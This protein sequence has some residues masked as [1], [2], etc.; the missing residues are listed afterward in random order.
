MLSV[1]W[2]FRTGDNSQSFNLKELQVQICRQYQ[3]TSVQISL[4][5]D[6]R[7]T[8]FLQGRRLN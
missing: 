5:L 7:S 3:E 1:R 8:T 6:G 4:A 2:L